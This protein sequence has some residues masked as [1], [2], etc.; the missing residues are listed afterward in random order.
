MPEMQQGEEYEED[1]GFEE[2]EEYEDEESDLEI[3]TFYGIPKNAVYLGVA[4]LIVVIIAVGIVMTWRKNKQ[5]SEVTD[6]AYDDNDFLDTA[7]E[8]DLSLDEI[9]DQSDEYYEETEDYDSVSVSNITVDNVEEL[10]RLGYTGDEIELA[11]DYG[12]NYQALVD[13]ATELRDEEA[14]QALERMSDT[15]GPEFKEIMNYTFMGQPEYVNPTGDRSEYEETRT[16]VKI[17]SDYVKCPVRGNQLWL[18][19]HIATDAYVWYQCPPVR[20][21]SLP[22]SGNIVLNIDFYLLNDNAYITGITEADSSLDSIDA[23][24]HSIGEVTYDEIS[25][26]DSEGDNQEDEG[27]EASFLTE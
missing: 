3:D 16:T 7:E 1:Y 9:Y 24:D 25:E 27:G 14:K 5:E 8:I 23:T 13:H 11:I 22:E 4:V 21:L 15:A 19:C 26:E 18:K 6:T 2:E 17:N 20:W 10:R 12:M